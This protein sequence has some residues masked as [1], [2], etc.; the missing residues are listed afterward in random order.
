MKN[1]QFTKRKG[2]AAE[3]QKQIWTSSTWI[4]HTESVYM[5]CYSR[6]KLIQFIIFYFGCEE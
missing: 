1:I 6:D 3:E 2:N 5:K 4:K